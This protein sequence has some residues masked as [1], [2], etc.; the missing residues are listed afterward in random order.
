MR[1][2]AIIIDDEQTGIDT[3]RFLIEKYITDVKIVAQTTIASDAIEL[4]ENYMPEI[5]VFN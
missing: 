5:V 4:I 3:L 2:R 1:L